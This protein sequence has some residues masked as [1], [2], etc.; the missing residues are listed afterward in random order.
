MTTERVLVEQE[1]HIKAAPDAVFPY[2]VDP[3]LMVRWM[4]RAAEIDAR[5]GGA[6]RCEMNDEN[7]FGGE[8]VECTPPSRLVFTF[9]WEAAYAPIPPGASTV[10]ITLEA[11]EGGTRVRLVHRDV[12]AAAAEI[13]GQG[14]RLYLDRLAIVAAGGDP[15]PDPN[16]NPRA[17]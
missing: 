1:V 13:H 12:P 17:M 9:G 11:A 10:E 6:I 15:G 2:L 14:W 7:I 16:A 8:I 4:G 3:A 5:P